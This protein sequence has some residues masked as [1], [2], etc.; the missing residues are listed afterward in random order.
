[1]IGR[2]F[3]DT[4]ILV[5]NFDPI[6]TRKQSIAKALVKRAA[7]EKSGCISM[8]VVQECLSLMISKFK[9]LVTVSDARYY[10][11]NVLEPLAEPLPA[12]MLYR[13][14]LSIQERWR[15]GFY[16]ALIMAS[17]LALDCDRLYSE[18]FQHG[19]RI[20]GLTVVNPF[21]EV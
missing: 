16:D 11:E 3:L 15:F 21:A 19:Q 17:A 6:D 18:D 7:S 20:E 2:F 8:Q 4:N 10:L 9:H 13:D 14:A 5:Y 1:M 12:M